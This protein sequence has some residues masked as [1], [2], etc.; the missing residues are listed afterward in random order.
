GGKLLPVAVIPTIGPALYQVGYLCFGDPFVRCLHVACSRNLLIDWTIKTH[1]SSHFPWNSAMLTRYLRQIG[2]LPLLLVVAACTGSREAPPER[3][4]E[5]GNEC[6][7]N[8]STCMY[9][10]KYEPDERDYAEAEAA[11]LNR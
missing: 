10:G 11:R 2:A 3:A 6:R 4:G 1:L 5:R 9:E 8:P 7:V